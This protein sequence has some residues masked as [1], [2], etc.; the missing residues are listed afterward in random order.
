MHAQAIE[1]TPDIRVMR[2]MTQWMLK[3]FGLLALATVLLLVSRSSL[4]SLKSIVVEGDTA[5]H[6]PLTLRANVAPRLSG[7]LFTVDLAQARQT[8][9]AQPWVRKAVVKRMFPN[10]LKVTLQE[11]DPVGL[12]GRSSGQGD[13]QMINTFGEVFEANPGEVDTEAMPKFQGPNQ[14][15]ALVLAMYRELSKVFKPLEL[16]VEELELS[17]RG[18]WRAVLDSGTV[19][20]LGRG[21]IAQVLE[22]T[23]VFLSTATQAAGQ[24]G[25][26]LHKDI[27]SADL[28]YSNGYAIRLK[29][30]GTVDASARKK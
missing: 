27:E 29:G 3:L 6:N 28:R 14:Q 11:H 12:W 1:L 22:R 18:S 19:L 8:F 5:H 16:D 17:G 23:R 20:E 15:S 24:W 4:F 7:N 10:Q 21:D 2:G 26:K 30:V 13:A 25:R 9:E